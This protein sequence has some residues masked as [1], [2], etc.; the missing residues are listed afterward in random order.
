MQLAHQKC[1]ARPITQRQGLPDTARHTWQIREEKN[2][3]VHLDGRSGRR[4]FPQA[5]ESQNW[6]R[7]GRR[8]RASAP[9]ARPRPGGPEGPPQ[10]CQPPPSSPTARSGAPP[11]GTCARAHPRFDAWRLHLCAVAAPLHCMRLLSVWP[12]PR[13]ATLSGTCS[14]CARGCRGRLGCSGTAGESGGVSRVRTTPATWSPRPASAGLRRLQQSQQGTA[15]SAGHTGGRLSH[16]TEAVRPGGLLQRGAH[17]SQSRP[18]GHL[19]SPGVRSL[20]AHGV[21][22]ASAVTGLQGSGGRAHPSGMRAARSRGATRRAGQLRA[23]PRCTYGPAGPARRQQAGKSLNTGLTT[24]A[25]SGC[26]GGG[27]SRWRRCR[28]HWRSRGAGLAAASAARAWFAHCGD[29]T[30]SPS[31]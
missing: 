27:G 19:C 9:P 12:D 29:A 20:S 15:Q 6:R 10:G 28:A 25:D 24:Q 11:G 3:S 16:N 21:G 5:W 18:G 17:Q 7:R 4:S 1:C 31:R 2:I 14:K 13:C 8:T 30:R 23:P 22:R 26:A